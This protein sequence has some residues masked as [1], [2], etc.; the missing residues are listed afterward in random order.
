LN[1]LAFIV[2]LSGLVMQPVRIKNPNAANKMLV[3]MSASPLCWR[4][5]KGQKNLL[6]DWQALEKAPKKRQCRARSH[7]CQLA[8]YLDVELFGWA[9]TIG[10]LARTRM[11]GHWKTNQQAHIA[12]A[13]FNLIRLR[14]LSA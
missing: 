14:D 6:P 1:A 11:I 2:G 3:F 9:K 8:V 4:R 12:G 13:A 7:P 5:K 10:G